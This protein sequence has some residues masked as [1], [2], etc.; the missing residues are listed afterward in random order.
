MKIIS[1]QNQIRQLVETM[2]P[3]RKIEV[4]G[5]RPPTRG[6]K[7]SPYTAY[8]IIDGKVVSSAQEKNWRTAYKTLQIKISKGNIL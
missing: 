7:K 4:C 3:D 5:E 1:P 6:G 8:L 2:Y